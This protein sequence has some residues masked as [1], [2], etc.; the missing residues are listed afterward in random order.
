MS[1]VYLGSLNRVK[2][3]AVQTVLQD[4]EV[5]GIE[6]DSTVGIQPFTDEETINGAYHRALGLPKNSLRF[7]LEAGVQMVGKMMYLVNWG[8]MIDESDCLYFA[9]GTRIPL[10][11]F[12]K[13][14]LLSE[15]TELAVVMDEYFKTND[16]KHN[17]GAIGV[18]TNNLVQRVD[19][20]IHIV[21]LLYGQYLAGQKIF[22]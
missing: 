12:V 20:F 19:I 8:V 18:F 15:K 14:K 17:Q 6:V 9:G 5:I 10:P 11:D 2:I 21:K 22:K 13:D 7:G 3:E 1:K 4:Y 16:I